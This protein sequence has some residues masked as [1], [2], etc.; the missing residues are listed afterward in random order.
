MSTGI[1][2]RVGRALRRL[3]AP[4]APTMSGSAER[5]WQT[6]EYAVADGLAATLGAGAPQGDGNSEI[7]SPEWITTIAADLWQPNAAAHPTLAAA[8]AACWEARQNSTPQAGPAI[9]AER[10][11]VPPGIPWPPSPARAAKIA[12]ALAAL[13][14]RHRHTL[15]L[16]EAEHLTH[17]E[18]A[19]RLGY[20]RTTT[21]RALLAR[22]AWLR[23]LAIAR[24]WTR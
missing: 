24:C 7:S 3:W 2:E 15:H 17:A 5:A 14:E 6:W 18:I 4:A 9:I 12:S 21:V 10:C 16:R 22:A 23:G 1:V 11:I 19:A 13:P 8:L 20:Q